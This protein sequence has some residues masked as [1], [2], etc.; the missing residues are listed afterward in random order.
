[1]LFT[2]LAIKNTMGWLL[3]KRMSTLPSCHAQSCVF[4]RQKYYI[5]FTWTKFAIITTFSREKRQRTIQKHSVVVFNKLWM[6]VGKYFPQSLVLFI[7]ES[8]L[9]SPN[10]FPDLPR[11][12]LET[13]DWLWGRLRRQNS[14]TPRSSINVGAAASWNLSKSE[15]PFC[16]RHSLT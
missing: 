8:S 15:G 6:A 1:M 12:L 3:E 10:L 5:Q 13:C 9:N 16:R 11:L 2:S 14:L 7:F 4:P